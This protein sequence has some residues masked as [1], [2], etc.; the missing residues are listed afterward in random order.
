MRPHEHIILPLDVPTVQR[1]IELVD[2]LKDD[3]GVFK[4]GLELTNATGLETLALLRQAG[5]DRIFYD[6]KLHDIPNT[7]AGAMRGIV[8]QRAWCVT[9]HT[10]G[11]KNMLKAAVDAAKQEAEE[12]GLPRPLVLGVTVLTSIS[13]NELHNELKVPTSISVQS[14]AT[15][16]ARLA[17][18]AGCDG[19]IA[20]PHEIQAIRAAIPSSDFLII[21]P[22]IR[23][24]GSTRGDQ[25][26]VH[27]PA[28]AMVRGASYLVIGRPIYA[29]EDPKAAAQNIAHEIEGAWDLV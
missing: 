9:V 3:V 21:T 18:E 8:R 28:E 24:A 12:R 27:T 19:V 6:A 14:Y 15:H 13:E 26:R 16:L 7:V 1:A 20:S 10:L 4:V 29:A 17:F 5:A 11:G 2:L 25:A 23:P 22:G